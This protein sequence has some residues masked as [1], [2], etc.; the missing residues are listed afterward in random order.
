MRILALIS[1]ILSGLVLLSILLVTTVAV[2][3]RYFLHTPI[4]FTEELSR[5]L[6]ILMAYGGS[7]ALPHL[8]EHMSV[9]FIYD[10]C[11]PRVR[12]RLD[13]VHLVVGTAFLAVLAY[14][15]FQLAQQMN[16]IRLPALQMPVSYLF[17]AVAVACG[18]HAL[19]YAK[20]AFDSLFRGIDRIAPVVNPEDKAVL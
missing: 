3:Y 15:G 6:L 7:I 4:L 17:G 10:M 1:T 11:S 16:G 9:E 13:Q 2:F 8:R 5:V 18:V 12:R 19:V 14:S 20:E